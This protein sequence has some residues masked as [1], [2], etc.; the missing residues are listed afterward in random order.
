MK[1]IVFS[2]S[3]TTNLQSS[4]L[5]KELKKIIA[6]V[7][8]CG[9]YINEQLFVK[10][11]NLQTAALDFLKEI[12]FISYL[13]NRWTPHPFLQ[14]MAEVEKLSVNPQATLNYW[15]EQLD[16]LPGHIQ[17]SQSLIFS[18]QNFGYEKKAEKYLKNA[19]QALYF[20]GKKNLRFMIHATEIFLSFS[21]LTETAFFLAGILI[22]WGQF[23]WAEQLLSKQPV[24][25]RLTSQVKLLRAQKHWRILELKESIALC[26]DVIQEA[27]A[28]S[29]LPK[30]Y[31]HRGIAYFLN[32]SWAEASADFTFVYKNAQDKHYVGRAQCM[33]GT[34][35]GIQRAHFQ[36]GQKHLEEGVRLL[37]KIK[38]FEGVWTGWNNL[39]EM[40][41]RSGEFKASA[42]Y[43]EKALELTPSLNQ[44][45]ARLETLRNLLQLHL[46][47]SGPLSKKATELILEMERFDWHQCAIYEQIQVLN[48][49]CTAYIL[50]KNVKKS[51]QFL[52]LLIPLTLKHGEHHYTLSNLALFF[53]L[54]GN[55]EKA[56]SFSNE[57]IQLAQKKNNLLAIQ[58]MKIDFARDGYTQPISKGGFWPA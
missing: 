12:G 40:F 15:Y 48:A 33:L 7:Y 17:A 43:L 55:N 2:F 16:E 19:I 14:E 46:R 54:L 52:K 49:L 22:D 45:S 23:D 34:V 21:H 27:K 28:S 26:S 51:S 1:K 3:K 31:F 38:D 8:S 6:A 44:E 30:A 32:G 10:Q 50:R 35:I 36:L 29:L 39:G 41:W 56:E 13:E 25:D 24:N 42:F 57:A 18:I 53:R 4:D 5:E 9:S 37:L 20:E 11:F 58:Q 47:L